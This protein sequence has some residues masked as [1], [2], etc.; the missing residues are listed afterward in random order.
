[1]QISSKV[2]SHTIDG[3]SSE[4]SELIAQPHADG[5]TKKLQKHSKNFQVSFHGILCVEESNQ[6]RFHIVWHCIRIAEHSNVKLTSQSS[7][8]VLSAH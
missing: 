6:T 5:S 3:V 7:S 8:N 2:I 4:C 1:M